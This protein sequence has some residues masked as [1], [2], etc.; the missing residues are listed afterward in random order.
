MIADLEARR[1]RAS[2]RASHRG[3]KEMDILL[4][5]FALARVAAMTEAD[6]DEFESL[7]EEPDPTLQQWIM[8]AAAVPDRRFAPLIA[9][10]RAFHALGPE[11]R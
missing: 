10:V 1:R 4:G 3:T 9:T 6:L 8:D 11:R 7:M 2:W 5:R